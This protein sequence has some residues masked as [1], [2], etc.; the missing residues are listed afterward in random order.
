MLLSK[1]DQAFVNRVR[2]CRF[3]SIDSEGYPHIVPLNVSADENY[4]YVSALGKRV[5]YVNSNPKVCVVIDDWPRKNGIM[6]RGMADIETAYSR[7]RIRP[8]R[9]SAWDYRRSD[10]IS[11]EHDPDMHVPFVVYL[12]TVVVK[13]NTLLASR[14]IIRR[15]AHRWAIPGGFSRPEEPF[16]EA[17]TR[18]V[19]E[20]TRVKIRF[21]G[22]LG[23]RQLVY[24]SQSMRHNEVHLLFRAGW[25]AGQP[26]PDGV[27]ADATEFLSLNDFRKRAGQ[28]SPLSQGY[29]AILEKA[30]NGRDCLQERRSSQ[31]L[32]ESGLNIAYV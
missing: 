26:V 18:L 28:F 17:V 23:V 15:N 32:P 16:S 7:I 12:S 29:I 24:G 22:L 13:G 11:S 9:Q 4:L 10:E 14:K 3:G 30:L 19:E 20:M 21:E 8:A 27:Q 25:I 6:I 31:K 1:E 5:N 2:M